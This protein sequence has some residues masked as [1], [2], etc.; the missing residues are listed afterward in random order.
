MRSVRLIDLA[1]GALDGVSTAPGSVD[2]KATTLR[3]DERGR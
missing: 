1:T 3:R 2:K